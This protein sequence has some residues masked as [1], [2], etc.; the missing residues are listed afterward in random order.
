MLTLLFSRYNII[1]HCLLLNSIL[2]LRIFFLQTFFVYRRQ[3]QGNNIQNLPEN[4]F[5]DLRS[6]WRL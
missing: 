5:S 3:L 6:L 1:L 2:M 4:V